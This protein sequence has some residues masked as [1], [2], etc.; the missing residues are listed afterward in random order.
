MDTLE[1]TDVDIE[2]QQQ[3]ISFLQVTLSIA[4]TRLNEILIKSINDE[5]KLRQQI[6]ILQAENDSLRTEEDSHETDN[7]N[8]RSQINTR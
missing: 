3:T 4:Q 5:A 8:G 7:N 6:N 2:E 1:N